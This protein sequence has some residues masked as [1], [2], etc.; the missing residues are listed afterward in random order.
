MIFLNWK[1]NGT[2]QL[3]EEYN[4][5][6]TYSHKIIVM[7]PLH[8]VLSL[9]ENKFHYGVQDV[10]SFANGAYTGEITAQM[11]EEMNVKFCLVGHSERRKYTNESNQIVTEKIKQLVAKNIT[12]VLCIGESSTERTSGNYFEIL[13]NQMESFMEGCIIA[14]EPIW[15]IGTGFTPTNDEINEITNWLK[16]EYENNLGKPKIL[17]GGSISSKNAEEISKTNVDGVLVGK[18]SL[19]ITEVKEILKYF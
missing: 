5:I 11:L 2:K 13:K 10:S 14:Y 16:Q 3:I 9:N 19:D 8:L 15:A 7:P 17:Y 18:S 1:A 4:N 6:D 12:P